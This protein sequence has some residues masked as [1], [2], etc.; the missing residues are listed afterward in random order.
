MLQD[1]DAVP[2]ATISAAATLVF[3]SVA[4]N[5]EVVTWAHVSPRMRPGQNRDIMIEGLE[6]LRKNGCLMEV[7]MD[8][9]ASQ[10]AEGHRE[11]AG[12]RPKR[13]KVVLQMSA[14][15]SDKIVAVK[16]SGQDSFPSFK[17]KPLCDWTANVAVLDAIKEEHSRRDARRERCLRST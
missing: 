11:E 9:G 2:A 17:M 3:A 15:L 8:A 10:D 14:A 12:A 5:F 13:R 1:V 4:K 16:R 7:E 6:V